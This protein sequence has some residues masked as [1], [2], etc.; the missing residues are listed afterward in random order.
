MNRKQLLYM[1][2]NW[3]ER[4]SKKLV[5]DVFGMVEWVKQTTLKKD[6]KL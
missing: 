3:K 6:K 5:N 1:L 2:K 4:R